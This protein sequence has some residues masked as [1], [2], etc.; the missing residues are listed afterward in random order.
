M[1]RRVSIAAILAA[2][3]VGCTEPPGTPRAPTNAAAVVAAPAPVQTVKNWN[4]SMQKDG[5]TQ[6]K[7]H[8]ETARIVAPREFDVESMRAETFRADGETDLI[9]ES[10]ACRVSVTTNGFIA[11]SPGALKITQA[12]G[13]FGLTGEGF[14]WDHGGQR[15]TVSNH[16]DSFH[17]IGIPKPS[18]ATR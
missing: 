1:M 18:P 8:G 15:L 4:F 3:L 7:F 16:V 2:A 17:S 5:R 13:R 11:T 12:D 10:P 14:R 6:G 9:A